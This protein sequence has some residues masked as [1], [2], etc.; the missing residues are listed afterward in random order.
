MRTVDPA[1]RT[2]YVVTDI[3]VIEEIAK[4]TDA[5]SNDFGHLFVAGNE[6]P[7]VA[8][9]LEQEPL[10]ATLLLGSD[11][12]DHT[13]YRALVNAVFA[14]GRVAHLT[15]LIEALADELID[16]F[17]E[18]GRCNFVDE[19]AVLLP[20][21]IIADILG[22][23]RDK[24]D[25]VKKWS[26]AVIMVVGRTGTKEDEIRAAHDIVDFRRYLRET[27]AARRIEPRDDL[28]SNLV[29]VRADGVRPFD[30]I[31]ATALAFEIAVAGNETTRNTLMGGLVQLVRHPDQMQA[32]IDDPSLVV[33]A[34]EEI[35]RYEAPASS[36]WRIAREDM[37]LAGTDIPAGATLLL[38]YD[39]GNRDPKRF[40]DPDRFD[41][42]RKNARRHI[43]F[44]APSVH[45]CMGQM[46]ARKELVIGFRKLL[47]RLQD[48][49]I[50]E[51]SNTSYQPSLLFH[52][53]GSL[54]ITFEPGERVQR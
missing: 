18:K 48:I 16:D 20:T 21:Y 37:T 52:A 46:L 4:R 30:D 40:E 34:V 32:L 10:R 54:N 2:I 31:E 24:Y 47:Q 35:L 45:T 15:P 43:S 11:A 19:F 38:R 5:F 9:I 50:A 49:R 7:E 13:R 6:H 14:T 33:N 1:G 22:L 27:V 23:P 12:P 25:V 42:Q 36:M 3:A 44:G 39:G 8:A 17:I 53:I 41:I 51:G 29:S 28:I 26:D